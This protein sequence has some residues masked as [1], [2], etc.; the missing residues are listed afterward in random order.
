MRMG[1][2]AE[3]R[4]VFAVI[5]VVVLLAGCTQVRDDASRPTTL[6]V[7]LFPAANTLPVHAAV[8]RGIFERRGLDVDIT[9]G[10][11]LPLFMAAQARGQY[12]ITMSTP[13]LALVGADKGVDLQIV[14]STAQ[15]TA[16]RPNAVWI[17][18]DP[19]VRSLAD[20]RGAT[21]AVP[22]LTGI[23][24]DAL[25]YLLQRN[26]FQ[27]NDFRLVQ[28]PFPA[29]GDQLEAGHVTA[30]VA[31]LPYSTAIL[32]RGFTA[33]DDVI[34]EAVKTASGG[35]VAE[36]ITTV[37]TVPRQFAVENPDTIT[38]WRESLREAIDTLKADQIGTRSLLSEWLEIPPSVLEKGP[39]P[40]WTVDITAHQ[41]EPYVAIAQQVGSIDEAPDVAT[42]VWRGP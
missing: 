38:A 4:R 35:A 39:L 12:D 19:S 40:D 41:L 9:E 31:T 34:V 6:R 37:W 14:S 36:A 7:A 26:G 2:F 42:L 13:T 17:T 25:V 30:A 16:E 8:V 24:T 21:I 10:Q 11:D 27:R 18:A 20:L 33:H 23:I 29:M 3:R 15:Q 32:A 22:S 1:S 28:T 5:T